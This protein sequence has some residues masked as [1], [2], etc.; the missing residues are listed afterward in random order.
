MGNLVSA[1]KLTFVLLGLHLSD[2]GRRRLAI[3][4][5]VTDEEPNSVEICHPLWCWC[6]DCLSHGAD[7]YTQ[8]ASAVSPAG[9]GRLF[10]VSSTRWV[11][12]SPRKVI[13]AADVERLAAA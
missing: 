8:P 11:P 3:T 7:P 5:T 4:T 6:D 12:G 10:R 1:I 2:N 9:G 13:G